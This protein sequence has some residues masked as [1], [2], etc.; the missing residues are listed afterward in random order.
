MAEQ[1][2]SKTRYRYRVPLRDDYST[3]PTNHSYED[4]DFSRHDT[5]ST[6]AD[7]SGKI[8]R[9]IADKPRSDDSARRDRAA[10]EVNEVIFRNWFFL[11]SDWGNRV[12]PFQLVSNFDRAPQKSGVSHEY[13]SRTWLIASINQVAKL[14][15]AT[16]LDSKEA[17]ALRIEAV[18]DAIRFLRHIP[19]DIAGPPSISGASDGEVVL[20]W[21]DQN[22]RAVVGFEGDGCFG[23]ALHIDGRYQPG[24]YHGSVD[25]GVPQDFLDYLRVHPV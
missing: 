16:N 13:T 17:T 6:V 7:D 23:Y 18:N 2:L 22:R 15:R 9:L 8:A 3:T 21:H 20:E 1:T 10:A 12:V 4:R 19:A 11:A 24:Q 14:N 25:S 5:S